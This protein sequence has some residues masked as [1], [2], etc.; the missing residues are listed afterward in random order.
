MVGMKG[1]S[2]RYR[3]PAI[4]DNIL[5]GLLS[6]I[7]GGVVIGIIGVIFAFISISSN[8]RSIT[9]FTPDTNIINTPEVL[10]GI[11]IPIVIAALVVGL[12]TAVFY[13]RAF[14]ILAEKSGIQRFRT[15][16]L[17]YLVS[18][19]LIGAV[20]FIGA[21]LVAINVI[22]IMVMFTLVLP[23]NIITCA[24]FLLATLGFFS[25]KADPYQAPAYTP[26]YQY[27]SSQVKYCTY[28]GAPNLLDAAYC[29]NCGKPIKPT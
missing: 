24:A 4:F 29:A 9:P 21:V 8:F 19:I 14:N 23:V 12:I 20:M 22:A 18:I 26:P 1:L 6:A 25:I 15:V 10:G 5:Y 16:G 27:A 17:L 11:F 7:V 13:K 3:T 28:C 2:T